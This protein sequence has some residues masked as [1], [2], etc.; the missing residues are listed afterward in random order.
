LQWS[1]DRYGNRSA[2][3]IYSGCQAPMTCPTN[4]VTIDAA[5]N[6][7][8][9]APYA[10]D[11]S[12]NMTND[13][14]NSLV[15]DAESR[16]VRVNS[17]EPTYVYDGAGLR[18]KKCSP[19]CTSPTTT[20]LYV[21]AG[22][23][24]LAEYANGSLSKEYIYSGSALIATHEG[25]AVKFHY[26]DHLSARVTSDSAGVNRTGQGH[27]P[28]GESWYNTSGS[29]WLFTSYERDSESGNDFAIFRYHVNRLGRFNA[30]DQV[31]GRISNP[32]RLNRYAYVMN[33]PINMVDPHGLDMW[34]WQQDLIHKLHGGSGLG[35]NPN[36]FGGGTFGYTWD[37]ALRASM[38]EDV[39]GPWAGGLWFDSMT[40]QWGV[41]TSSWSVAYEFVVSVEYQGFIY[42]TDRIGSW[43]A[44]VAIAVQV[45]AMIAADQAAR[46]NKVMRAL[47]A[48]G[49]P[50]AGKE[51][52]TIP[53]VYNNS[54]Y[55][56]MAVWQNGHWNIPLPGQLASQ[57]G[58]LEGRWGVLRG[59][60]YANGSFHQDFFNP[61][62]GPFFVGAGVHFAAD[63]VGGGIF[64]VPLDQWPR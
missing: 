5:T 25:G 46:W 12:G 34:D 15:Y 37:D 23:Q 45:G 36:A 40:G 57:W 50:E 4:S 43:D 62:A 22:S 53:I 30:P 38:G 20:T 1:Y 39:A 17:S 54:V 56:G 29:K 47:A 9:G 55:A 42:E 2:Q 58:L 26:S 10:Y 31:L 61:Y 32:Q 63:V 14:A 41:D 27:F 3:S 48:A 64:K 6:R 13:G 60:H 16:V 24:V 18:V 21:F 33:N 28:Y 51:G 59:A 19:N 52:D 35:V 11:A 7:L 8:T 44:A 49:M